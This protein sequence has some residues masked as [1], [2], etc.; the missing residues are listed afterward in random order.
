MPQFKI[1][2]LP[3]LQDMPSRLLQN[4]QLAFSWF[5][6]HTKFQQSFLM[7]IRPLLPPYHSSQN[8]LASLPPHSNPQKKYCTFDESRFGL[9]ENSHMRLC[10]FCTS[11]LKSIRN[12]FKGLNAFNGIFP[13]QAEISHANF[14]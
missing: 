2:W 14:A 7:T 4:N 10:K 5:H 1:V 6:L 13:L 8:G 12:I 9:F 3:D 11:P